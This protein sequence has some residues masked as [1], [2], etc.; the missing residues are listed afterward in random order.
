MLILS[1]GEL[2]ASGTI[3]LHRKKLHRED[4]RPG[5]Q[6]FCI[7]KVY[8]PKYPAPDNSDQTFYQTMVGHFVIWS[9]RYISPLVDY[10]ESDREENVAPNKIKDA[11][12]W[13][14]TDPKW[15]LAKLMKGDLMF[16]CFGCCKQFVHRK[17]ISNVVSHISKWRTLWL[18]L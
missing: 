12:V 15:K 8:D 1:E 17:Q 6:V 4:V 3:D 14:P 5:F 18:R 7:V 2:I 13:C 10:E 11:K 9:K 16:E